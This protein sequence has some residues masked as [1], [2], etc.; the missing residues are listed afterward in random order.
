MKNRAQKFW[1]LYHYFE[2]TYSSQWNIKFW[3]KR[4]WHKENL[5]HNLSILLRRR[6][7][8]F[9]SPI[10][11]W[12]TECFPKFVLLVH[13][14]RNAFQNLCYW[15]KKRMGFQYIM[16]IILIRWQMWSE[17]LKLNEAYNSNSFLF[18]SWF[19]RLYVFV[20]RRAFYEFFI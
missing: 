2:I 13:E 10:S 18:T 14:I 11:T 17:V 4:C 15:T 20:F 6:S 8:T 19:M 3:H 9:F 1:T 16:C 7:S 12:D 5:Q